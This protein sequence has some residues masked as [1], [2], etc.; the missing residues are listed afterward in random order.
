MS[1][2]KI[3]LVERCEFRVVW[4]SVVD[5]ELLVAFACSGRRLRNDE[6]LVEAD[7]RRR[8]RVRWP[9]KLGGGP[10]AAGEQD[11]GWSQNVG[12]LTSSSTER[13]S[14]RRTSFKKLERRA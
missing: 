10:P 1:R 9:F 4:S 6:V 8:F 12:L 3:E 7:T 14:C 2:A 5:D 13:F 11:C